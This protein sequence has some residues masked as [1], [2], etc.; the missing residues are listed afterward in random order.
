MNLIGQAPVAQWPLGR[1]IAADIVLG[2]RQFRLTCGKQGC[3][4]RKQTIFGRRIKR[5]TRYV[6]GDEM[7]NEWTTEDWKVGRYLGDRDDAKGIVILSG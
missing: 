7:A 6:C 1:G 2:E 4:R 3:R 5:G